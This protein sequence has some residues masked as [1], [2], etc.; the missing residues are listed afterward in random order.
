MDP[1]DDEEI[2]R[3]ILEEKLKDSNLVFISSQYPMTISG[4]KLKEQ[5]GRYSWDTTDDRQELEPA[6]ATRCGQPKLW[7]DP[8]PRSMWPLS[9]STWSVKTSPMFKRSA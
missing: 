3:K 5:I 2:N 1:V 6:H 8:T 4:Y 7:K 9:R